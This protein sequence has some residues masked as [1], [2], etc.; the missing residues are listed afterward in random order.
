MLFANS[1]SVEAT[2]GN[3]RPSLPR[4]LK[5]GNSLQDERFSITGRLSPWSPFPADCS[6]FMFQPELA[7]QGLI[8]CF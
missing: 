8:N 2:D 1:Q 4:R 7:P 6:G 5:T 3:E